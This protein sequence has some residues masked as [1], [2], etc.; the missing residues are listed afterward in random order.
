MTTHPSKL[1]NKYILEK[2][3]QQK[4]GTVAKKA[5]T[6]RHGPKAKKSDI[7]LSYT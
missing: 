1:P 2:L 6:L 5:G 4:I 7:N 3:Q